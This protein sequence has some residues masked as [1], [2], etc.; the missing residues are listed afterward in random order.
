MTKIEHIIQKI[1]YNNNEIDVEPKPSSPHNL[2]T[3]KLENKIAQAFES[4]DVDYDKLKDD[5][6]NLAK[7]QYDVCDYPA[8]HLTQKIKEQLHETDTTVL[9]TI[10]FQNITFNDDIIKIK[11]INGREL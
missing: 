11:L 10:I 2:K 6:F 8:R 9:T 3:I 7:L 1:K 4:R 5:I